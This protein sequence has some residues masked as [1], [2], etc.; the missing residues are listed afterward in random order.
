MADAARA[1]PPVSDRAKAIAA[2]LAQHG[3]SRAERRPLA[4]DASFRRYDRLTQDGKHAVLMDAPP[5]QE[6]VRPFLRIA[7]LLHNLGYSAPRIYAADAAQGLLLLEDLGDDTY[8]RLLRTG[9]DERAL[10][11]L[12]VDLL[13]DLH[14]RFVPGRYAGL[15]PFDDARALREAT[16][17]LDWYWPATQ[18]ERLM[19]ALREGFLAAWREVLPKRRAA[20]DTLVLFDFHVDNLM[21]LPGR[22]GIAACGLLDFQDA[23]IAPRPFDLVALLQDVRR[24]VSAGLAAAMRDRYLAGIGDLRA[25]A[26]DTS[27]A[28]IGAQRNTRILGTFT[29]LLLRDG[30]P[31]YLGFMPRTWKLLEADLAHPA[32]APLRA[33][34]DAHLP[35]AARRAPELGEDLI[36]R[37]GAMGELKPPQVERLRSLVAR[38]PAPVPAAMPVAA[39]ARGKSGAGAMAAASRPVPRRAMVLAAGFGTRLKPITEATPKPMVVV[40]GRPMIDTVLDRLAAVGVEDTV[41]NTHHL[42]EVIEAHLQGRT[43]P[44]IAFSREEEILETG[45]GIAKALPLLG[46]EPFYAV[47]GKIVWL[48]GKV[49]AL[50]R[51]AETWDDARMDALLLLQP[52]ATAVGYGGPG[53]FFLD[54]LGAVRRRR[55]WEVA[56]FVYAGIQILHPRL[57]QGAPGGAFSLNLLY[58]RAIEA[59]R[60][61][62]LRHDGEWFHVSTPQQLAEVEA[63]I[64]HGVDRYI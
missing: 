42:A 57:F 62:G 61:Y 28:V 50:I 17:L 7:E 24:D 48:N 25:E 55:H 40:A 49:D 41:V 53:D 46:G 37:A 26:F 35:P 54:Q 59:G 19:P 56:P 29:R 43:A 2:F 5:P 20:P 8:T 14:H 39:A 47:N 27:Y 3:W 16:L 58:D 30:K 10:Y 22:N 15:P 23:V 4:G 31:G 64:A 63:R 13:I 21:L 36:R 60:L 1:Q 38:G 11:T 52:T 12:A 9:H 32:L 44:R 18:D 6:D 45:G 33:W 51:L 34:F